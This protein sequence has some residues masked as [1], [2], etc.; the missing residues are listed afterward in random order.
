MATTS[1]PILV[2]VEGTNG[3]PA[4][5]ETIRLET[6]SGP[7]AEVTYDPSV[8]QYTIPS[9]TLK[10]PI[11]SFKFI[12]KDSTGEY[13]PVNVKIGTMHVVLKSKLEGKNIGGISQDT[14]VADAHTQ[15]KKAAFL[16]GVTFVI[17]LIAL[18]IFFPVPSDFQYLVFRIVLALA[19]AGVASMIPGLLDITLPPW[20]KATGALAVF[21]LLFFYNPAALVTSPSK[22]NTETQPSLPKPLTVPTEK[23]SS[24]VKP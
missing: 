14:K 24:S 23:D 9:Y 8:K 11:E 6:P 21:V 19:G 16:F 1:N 3:L 5:F 13:P 2:I 20:L 15:E 7:L 18:A 12:L 10:K 4:P 17:V 22:P